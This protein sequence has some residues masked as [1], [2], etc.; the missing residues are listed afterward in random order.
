MKITN[1]KKNGKKRGF[2]EL[3]ILVCVLLLGILLLIGFKNGVFK[4]VQ[5]SLTK[6]E[7]QIT[8]WNNDLFGSTTDPTPNP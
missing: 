1:V 3:L 8:D 6:V 2:N 4:Q 7:Q 5:E